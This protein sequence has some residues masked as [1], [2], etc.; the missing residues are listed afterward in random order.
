MGR[1]QTRRM[2]KLRQAHRGS[3]I[4]GQRDARWGLLPSIY[5][6]GL[7]ELESDIRGDFQQRASLLNTERTPSTLTVSLYIYLMM[8]VPDEIFLS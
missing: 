2:S 8:L 3:T 1:M 6:L 5:R 7:G 4:R